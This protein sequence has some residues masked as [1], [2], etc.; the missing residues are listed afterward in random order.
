MNSSRRLFVSLLRHALV[1]GGALGAALPAARAQSAFVPNRGQ[2]DAPARWQAVSGEQTAWFAADGWTLVHE[3]RVARRGVAL[4]FTFVDAAPAVLRG[5]GRRTEVRHWFTGDRAVTDVPAYDALHYAEIY[6]GTNVRVHATGGA[7]EYDLCLAPGADPAR[8]VLR[9]EGADALELADDGAL[10]VHTALGILRQPAPLTWAVLPDGGREEL[11]CRYRLLDG[12]RFGFDVPGADGSRPV[13][14][15][16]VLEWASYLGGSSL[17]YVYAVAEDAA[18][19][20][21]A[22]STTVSN[23]PTTTGAYDT[24]WNGQQDAFVSR[25]APDGTTLLFSSF[26]GGSK[27]EE[28]RAVCLDSSGGI[29]VAGWTASANFP[30]GS[31]SFD[32][33]YNGGAGTLRSDAFVTRLAPGGSAL[34]FSSYLGGSKDDFASSV[35]VDGAGRVHVAGKTSSPEFPTTLGAFDRTHNGGSIEVGDAFVA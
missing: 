7:L 24:S 22:G 17:E 23:Y 15:D 6:P 1:L 32:K 10:L 14:I 2:W 27:D 19:L 8:I 25:L 28:A 18:G 12:E 31:T 13:I 35:G 9:C 3:S 29:V 5:E 11:P 30:T 16:P 26:L 4:R 33:S 21:V 34:V 20:T